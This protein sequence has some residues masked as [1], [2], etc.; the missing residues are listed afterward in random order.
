MQ[1][2]QNSKGLSHRELVEFAERL[3]NET[4]ASERFLAAYD[5]ALSAD[6]DRPLIDFC[7]DLTEKASGAVARLA[8]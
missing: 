7:R 5:A 3:M 8:A 4:P 6:N 2:L 1:S